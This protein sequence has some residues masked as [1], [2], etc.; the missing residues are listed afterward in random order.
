MSMTTDEVWIGC[1]IYWHHL[2]TQLGTTSSYRA[3]A[4]STIHKSSQHPLSLFQPAVSSPAVPWQWLLTVE[5]LQLHT[6]KFC[7][8]GG[9][10]PTATFPHRL[11]YRTD[12]QLTELQTFWFQNLST[13]HLE[14]T[15]LLLLWATESP[16]TNGRVHNNINCC[17]HFHIFCI[18]HL[19][20]IIRSVYFSRCFVLKHFWSVLLISWWR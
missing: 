14:K 7:L 19:I 13:D 2:Y 15:V 17:I 11:L 20:I 9:S 6:L 4:I 1:W 18:F 12:S 5:I 3:T 10:L 8:N 16:L